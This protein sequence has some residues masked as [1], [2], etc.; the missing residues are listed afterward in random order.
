[1]PVCV[2]SCFVTDS[3]MSERGGDK[4]NGSPRRLRK[5]DEPSS[6]ERGPRGKECLEEVPCNPQPVPST[7]QLPPSLVHKLPMI[8][9]TGSPPFSVVLLRNAVLKERHLTLNLGIR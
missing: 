3:G 1:M 2:S 4:S 5:S 9:L 6:K 8:N 7:S